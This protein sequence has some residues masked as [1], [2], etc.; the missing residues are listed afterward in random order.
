MASPPHV[1][2]LSHERVRRI[3]D[4]IGSLQ[5]TQAFYE[6]PAT[7]LLV[8]R[9]RFSDAHRIFELGCGTGRLASRILAERAPNH[10]AYQGV[11][12]SPT[13][14][15]LARKRMEPFGER[16][17]VELS[18][19]GPP[20]QKPSAVYDRFLSTYVFDL[21][22][23]D[24]IAAVLDQAHR[25]LVPGGMLCLC[26]LS[27]GSGITSRAVS[28]VWALAHRLSPTLV[29]GCRPIELTRYLEPSNWIVISH[30]RVAP[31]AIPSE[32]VVAGRVSAS[33]P[34]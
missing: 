26:S 9:A 12:V 15:E 16:A 1:R 11:D 22:S 6:D 8:H 28:E 20:V 23:D 19:G 27:S 33:A 5:D 32:V 31:F 34:S 10:A 2:T 24:D 30:D 29:G 7:E 17:S 25:M 3:Y 13:M 18:E 4:R 21:L 14:V